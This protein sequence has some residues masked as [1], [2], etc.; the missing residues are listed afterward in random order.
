MTKKG[1]S[2]L[3]EKLVK[4]QVQY[5]HKV[6]EKKHQKD[7][8]LGLFAE[9][10]W[11]NAPG[12]DVFDGLFDDTCGLNSGGNRGWDKKGVVNFWG[13]G[14]L[15]FSYFVDVICKTHVSE[16]GFNILLVSD[17][18]DGLNICNQFSYRLHIDLVSV[19]FAL[20]VQAVCLAIGAEK[21]VLILVPEQL[22]LCKAELIGQL[23]RCGA[24]LFKGRIAGELLKE[25]N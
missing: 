14:P 1:L 8:R 7:K 15:L 20:A 5:G 24:F 4:D 11:T 2:P 10:N 21:I 19:L 3:F 13:D 12:G 18:L 6:V 23:Y 22:Q 17:F 16:V 9:L 25:L